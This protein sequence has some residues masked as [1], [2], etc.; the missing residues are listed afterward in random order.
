[1]CFH[2]S[3]TATV[4][5]VEKRFGAKKEPKTAEYEPVYHGN[6][7]EFP[8]WPVITAQAPN[9]LQFYKWGL[10]APLGQKH[11]R[12]QRITHWYAQCQGRNIG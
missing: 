6:G 2:N 3:L 1:M 12:S 8:T 9:S 7:F 10:I 11:A 5:E 4:E